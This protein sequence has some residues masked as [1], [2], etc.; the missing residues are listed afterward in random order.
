MF[1]QRMFSRRIE[2]TTPEVTICTANLLHLPALNASPGHG[3][4]HSTISRIS[5]W[6]YSLVVFGRPPLHLGPVPGIRCR[7]AW[8]TASTYLW[9][10][11]SRCAMSGLARLG[12][13]GLQHRP[14]RRRIAEQCP[15][16]VT[17]TLNE[18]AIQWCKR[19]VVCTP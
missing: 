17:R 11:S 3:G 13:L 4:R 10:Q 15:G 18:G 8:I 19:T 16:Q 14:A 9:A 5:R 6:A 2:A 12:R 1:S 7:Y